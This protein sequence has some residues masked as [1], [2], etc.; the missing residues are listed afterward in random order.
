MTNK[1]LGFTA[2]AIGRMVRREVTR[3]MVRDTLAAGLPGEAF[4]PPGG[5]PRLAKRLY[6]GAHELQVVYIESATER[7]VITVEW[8]DFW[9]V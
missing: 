7:L 8:L 2:H 6:F 9:K 5:A 3:Q 4:T 1:P